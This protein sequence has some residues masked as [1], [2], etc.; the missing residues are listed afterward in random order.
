M[1]DFHQC[2]VLGER[3]RQVLLG[4][5]ALP[6]GN[7]Q[8]LHLHG[9]SSVAQQSGGTSSGAGSNEP[10][11]LLPRQ[12]GLQ[13]WDPVTR[14]AEPRSSVATGVAERVDPAARCA[15]EVRNEPAA[16]T[17]ESAAS[18]GVDGAAAWAAPVLP[19]PLAAAA[20]AVG[21][22]TRTGSF[23]GWLR[24]WGLHLEVGAA[25]LAGVTV[26]F[27]HDAR[28]HTALLALAVWLLGSYHTGRAVTTPLSRQFRSLFASAT[29]P[30][31]VVAAGVAFAGLSPIYIS[32][33][34]TTLGAAGL[35][36]VI[37]RTVRWTWQAPVRVVVVGDRAA[38]ASATT[39]WTHGSSVQL[40]GGLVVEPGLEA[41]AVPHDMLGV[42]AAP[43]LESARSLVAQWK[44]D[45]VIVTPGAG[46]TSE[47]FRRVTWA[48]EGSRVAIG[49]SGLLESVS[50]HR[51]TPGRLDNIGVIGVRDPRP[52]TVVRGIKSAIDRALG[53]VLLLLGAPLLLLIAAAI[54]IDSPGPALFTQTRVGKGGKPFTIYKMRTM[55]A[56]A[57]AIKSAL[58]SDNEFDSVLFKMR[59]DPRITRV[60]RF[61]RKSSLDELPQLINVVKGDMSL[62]GPRPHLPQEVAEMDADTLRRHAVQPGITGLWQ[63]S[64]RSDLK[65]DDAVALDT[66]YA[67]NWSISGDARIA[68]RTVKAVLAAKGAY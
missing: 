13:S 10:P 5:N 40:V 43:G 33:T 57:D 66:Y 25:F 56:E 9:D 16:Q 58:A 20:T 68:A 18:I 17:A 44:A 51:I 53:A 50:P 64:G 41:A 46:M 34:F 24:F 61:L 47:V 60:G 8:M 38:L 7:A 2:H 3:D 23:A 29:L 62:V 30:L 52:S 54:R 67:D 15:V 12:R 65:W 1:E 42:P 48:L 39:R 26:A 31:A 4:I 19:D 45:I 35:A 49:V 27:A 55:V 14:D 36:S 22:F 6:G 28:P 11:G 21:S 59:A 32:R 37:C 63:V